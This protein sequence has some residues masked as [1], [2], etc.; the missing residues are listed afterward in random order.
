MT[1]AHWTV[2]VVF[3]T[4]DQNNQES[5]EFVITATGANTDSQVFHGKNLDRIYLQVEEQLTTGMLKFCDG[6][7]LKPSLYWSKVV[8]GARVGELC[9]L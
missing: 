4:Q 9:F 1:L 2:P 8:A 7:M 5:R 3:P 6:Y